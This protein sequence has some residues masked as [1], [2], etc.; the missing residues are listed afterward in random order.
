MNLLNEYIKKSE[1]NF[2]NINEFLI[3]NK[4]KGNS[5]V[6]KKITF[7]LNN[8]GN[9]ISKKME[10]LNIILNLNL[11]EKNNFINKTFDVFNKS[12]SNSQEKE[13]SYAVL[14]YIFE[15]NISVQEFIKEDGKINIEALCDF[16]DKN[17]E[18]QETSQI[19]MVKSKI[20]NENKNKKSNMKQ[21]TK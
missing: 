5:D 11:D 12:I 3:S 21:E 10:F 1:E 18:V 4:R 17:N 20:K 7:L 2:L 16:Y 19:S 8:F 13:K 15:N 9:D 6:N 14:R